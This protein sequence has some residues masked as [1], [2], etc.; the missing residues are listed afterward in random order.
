MYNNTLLQIWEI[1]HAFNNFIISIYFSFNLY[2]QESMV[3]KSIKKGDIEV[4]TVN[5]PNTDN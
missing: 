2:A 4:L 1:K 5:N 3:Y